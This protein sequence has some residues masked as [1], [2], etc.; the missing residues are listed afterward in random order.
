MQIGEVELISAGALQLP[1]LAVL[2]NSAYSDYAV[3]MA[4]DERGLER[5][6]A[7]NDIDLEI[8]CVAC[9][10]DPVGFA[11]I[12]RREREAWVG[13]MGTV[14]GYRRRG[15]GERT[16]DAALD[17]AAQSGAQ[18]A[19]LEVL[20][21]NRPAIALYERLGFEVT[22]RL[23]VCALSEPGPPT[24][25]W[26]P[27]PVADARRWIAGERVSREPWQR[28]DPVLERMTDSGRPLAALDIRDASQL[29]AALV[30]L[31]GPAG[32]GILQMAARDESAAAEGLR[33]AG[34]A[35]GTPIRLVNFPADEPIAAAVA[36]LG[37]EPD[38]IQYEMRK[39]LRST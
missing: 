8:S 30:Y 16:L 21:Q 15:L 4:F 13:G 19:W 24:A 28:D 9:S 38:H 14:P 17:A 35:V 18:S 33:A 3:P 23:I 34:A 26:G 29:V 36:S 27:M 7:D 37:I 10:P 20:E 25:E 39:R 2:F 32:T 6:L 22:R 5:Y 12:G 1:Q 31:P 11:L